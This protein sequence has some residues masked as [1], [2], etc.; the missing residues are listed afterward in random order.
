MRINKYKG[1][2]KKHNKTMSYNQHGW[3]PK[4]LNLNK[5]NSIDTMKLNDVNIYLNMNKLYVMKLMNDQLMWRGY[6][7]VS[8]LNILIPLVSI[9]DWFKYES[10]WYGPTEVTVIYSARDLFNVFLI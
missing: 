1:Y 6:N 9:N 5:S 3:T 8:C 7:N 10:V 2:N 4:I